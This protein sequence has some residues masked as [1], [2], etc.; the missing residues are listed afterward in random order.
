LLLRWHQVRRGTGRALREIAVEAN[1]LDPIAM[2]AVAQAHFRAGAVRDE[3]KDGIGEFGT[4]SELFQRGESGESHIRRAFAK[5]FRPLPHYSPALGDARIDD[6]GTMRVEGYIYTVFL[7][8]TSN[9]RERNW[10][11]FAHPEKFSDEAYKTYFLEGRM[12]D[13]AYFTAYD[14]YDGPGRGPSPDKVYDDRPFEGKI[15]AVQ[16][17]S[18]VNR[19]SEERMDSV[20]RRIRES[21]GTLWTSVPIVYPPGATPQR[22]DKP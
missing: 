14:G 22:S 7:P 12:P 17:P 10:C 5:H 21:Q 2:I 8:E 16:L 20:V 9:G 3:D 4:I 18:S 19:E 15:R 1:R 13:K 6:D 11:V